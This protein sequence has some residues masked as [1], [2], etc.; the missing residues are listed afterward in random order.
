MTLL[1]S[2]CSVHHTV[3]AAG[4]VLVLLG[5]SG[6]AAVGSAETGSANAESSLVTE[7]PTPEP[8]SPESTEAA[9]EITC[10]AYGDV[11]TILHNAQTAYF[12]DRMTQQELDGWFAVASRVLG[13]IPAAETGTVSEALAALQ[14]AVPPVPDLRKTNFPFPDV[15][16][17]GVE[18]SEACSEAGFEIAINAFTGG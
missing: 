3:L 8:A 18:L 14:E 7:S 6:C 13:N 1:R 16:L 17:P 4:A 2:R 11:V 12:E 9:D 5:A 10:A 15:D